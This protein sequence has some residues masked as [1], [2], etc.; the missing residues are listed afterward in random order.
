M[1]ALIITGGRDYAFTEDDIAWL[2]WLNDDHEFNLVIEGGCR[3]KDYR[4]D[5][6]PTADYCGY[7]WARSRGIQ[8]AT[9]DANWDLGKAGG[10]IRNSAM[11]DLGQKL[12]AIVAAFPGG[13][14]TADMA[15]KAEA[16]G[17]RVVRR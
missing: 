16:R 2:N 9:M 13:R 15:A 6:L 7:M 1:T 11:A 17:L 8:T 12:G 5:D 10:P 14:G 4:G 3:R